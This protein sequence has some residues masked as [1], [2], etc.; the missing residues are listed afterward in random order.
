[1]SITFREAVAEVELGLVAEDQLPEIATSGLFEG[2]DSP[3]LAALAGQFGEPSDPI[4]FE[5]LWTAA[6]EELN[7]PS[8]GR[9]DA[10]RILVRAYARLVAEGELP[11]QLGAS[12]IAGVHRIACHPGCD[13]RAVGDCLDAASVIEL[14]CTHDGHGYL[15]PTEYDRLDRAIAQ[16]CRRLAGLPVV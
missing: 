3:A 14:F 4:E 11:P 1:M 12:K 16:E 10:A 9:K 5:R 6:L 2:Y 13:T 7:M 8:L 15:N